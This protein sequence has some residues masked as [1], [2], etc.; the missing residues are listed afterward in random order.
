MGELAQPV[1]TLTGEG[2]KV[3]LT[4]LDYARGEAVVTEI[5]NAGGEAIFQ[6]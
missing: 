6:T 3:M 5:G 2:A 1:A 4:N